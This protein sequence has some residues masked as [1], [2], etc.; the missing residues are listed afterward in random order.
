ML[1]TLELCVFVDSILYKE[2][3]FLTFFLSK[4]DVITTNFSVSDA[5]LFL[6]LTWT[7]HFFLRTLYKLQNM[8]V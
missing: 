1:K 8:F 2:R 3:T 5:K 4:H 6:S 7:E